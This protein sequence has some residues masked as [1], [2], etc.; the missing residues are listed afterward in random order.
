[1]RKVLL[2]EDDN[3]QVIII[4]HIFD[5]HFPAVDLKIA[6]TGKEAIDYLSVIQF[7]LVLLDLGLPDMN[8][9]DIISYINANNKVPIVVLTGD[10]RDEMLTKIRL[11]D[12]TDYVMKQVELETFVTLVRSI[13]IDFK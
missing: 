7:D 5:K 12:V 13:L 6:T 2:V 9:T 10:D 4:R 3:F 1:M 11:I 8:G